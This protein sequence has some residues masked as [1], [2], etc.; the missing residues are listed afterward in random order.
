MPARRR[1]TTGSPRWAGRPRRTSGW[2]SWSRSTIRLAPTTGP[3]SARLA[4]SRGRRRT[5]LDDGWLAEKVGPTGQVVATDIEAGTCDGSD[6]PNVEVVE[7]NILEDQSQRSGPARSTWSARASCCSTL[8]SRKGDQADGELLAPRR[9]ARSTKMPTGGRPGLRRSRTPRYAAYHRSGGRRL[10][11]GRGYDKAFGRKLP[12][13]FERCGLENVHIRRPRRWFV[14]AHRGR[15]GGA[16][17][18]CHKRA[19][20]GARRGIPGASSR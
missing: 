7:H 2:T 19:R 12:V 14:V 18:G 16:D 11:G 13:L 17:P 4:V 5:W 3:G 20:G 15:D 10:V 6:L 1:P 9:L 8:G